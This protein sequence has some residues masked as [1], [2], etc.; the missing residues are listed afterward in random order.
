MKKRKKRHI[1]KT[2]SNIGSIESAI[3]LTK[4]KPRKEEEKFFVKFSN[5]QLNVILIIIFI[6]PFLF[7]GVVGYF[8]I[9]E[10]VGFIKPWFIL[11]IFALGFLVLSV[12]SI[13]LGTIIFPLRIKRE[14]N[15]I[16]FGTFL[17]G[18]ALFLLSLLVLLIIVARA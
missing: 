12:T 5:T 16:S 1:K 14:V 10:R 8:D 13:T 6:I 11:N 2:K 3:E 15:L 9:H 7:D 17:G 4:G 18:L